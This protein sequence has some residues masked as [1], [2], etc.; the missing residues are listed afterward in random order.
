MSEESRTKEIRA[1]VARGT[2]GGLRAGQHLGS[3]E[4]HHLCELLEMEFERED[5]LLRVLRTRIEEAMDGSFDE[6]FSEMHECVVEL[7]R[8]RKT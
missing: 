6:D 5:M 2:R 7:Q 1:L 8:G 4:V 3:D